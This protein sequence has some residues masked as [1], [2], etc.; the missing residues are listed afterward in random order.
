MVG[1]I[2]EDIR[3]DKEEE[4]LLEGSNDVQ[5]DMETIAQLITHE[6]GNH[7]ESII[8]LKLR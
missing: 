1:N 7:R 3:I 6:M 5:N 2:N 8:M 4:W